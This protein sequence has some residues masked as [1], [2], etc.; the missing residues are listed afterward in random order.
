MYGVS[1]SDG[2]VYAPMRDGTVGGWSC[3]D[4]D[5]LDMIWTREAEHQVIRSI[6]VS[7]K[8]GKVFAGS[9][10]GYFYAIHWRAGAVVWRVDV[11]STGRSPAISSN[12]IVYF[13]KPRQ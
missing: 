12:G 6:S 9:L 2:M 5:T 8:D 11:G 13:G 1:Y 7:S 4:T 3:L 10:D